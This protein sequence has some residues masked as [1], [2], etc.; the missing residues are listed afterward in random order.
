MEKSNKENKRI[1][2]QVAQGLLEK[3]DDAT[4][5]KRVNRSELIR[6]AIIKYLKEIEN[7]N[8]S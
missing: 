5:I 1:S 4:Y 3:I 2:L 6:I 8:V 7:D